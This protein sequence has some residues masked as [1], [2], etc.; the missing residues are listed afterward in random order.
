MLSTI[1]H[2]YVQYGDKFLLWNKTFPSDKIYKVMMFPFC[3][4]VVDIKGAHNLVGMFDLYSQV[5]RPCIS[6]DC[7]FDNLDNF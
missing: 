5:E 7:T 4:F 2:N 3:L 1:L 6:C